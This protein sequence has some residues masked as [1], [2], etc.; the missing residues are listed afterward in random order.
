MGSQRFRRG[1]GTVTWPYNLSEKIRDEKCSELEPAPQAH[2]L[3]TFLLSQILPLAHLLP[4]FL[5]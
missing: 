2:M 3:S 1:K 4:P 5:S